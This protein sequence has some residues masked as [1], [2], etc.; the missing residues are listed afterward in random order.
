M[1]AASI[2]TNVLLAIFITLSG[3]LY[4]VN[5]TTQADHLQNVAKSAGVYEGISEMVSEKLAQK[6]ANNSGL[7]IEEAEKLVPSVITD[8]YVQKVSRDFSDQIEQVLSGE[9]EKIVID[10]SD[11]TAQ[12]NAQG[13]AINTTDLKPFEIN[14]PANTDQGVVKTAQNL[15]VFQFISYVGT[16]LLLIT[17]C[18]LAFLRRSTLGLGLAFIIS[19]IN[20]VA[21]L[22]INHILLSAALK[23]V[24]LP[25]SVT[26]ITPYVSSFINSL[27]AS[28]NS[29]YTTLSISCAAMGVLFI[30][31]HKLLKPFRLSIPT[32]SNQS[33]TS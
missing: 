16:S 19:A 31:A 5:K 20:F 23:F 14:L 17:S 26:E 27:F 10:F 22:L 1:K 21:L 11:L 7:S 32:Q 13:L 15:A 6:V 29:V 18:V 25:K 3:A 28:M 30:I 4:V 12:A 24:N 33:P 8:D 9:S 2:I